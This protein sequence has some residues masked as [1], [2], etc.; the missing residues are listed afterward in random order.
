MGRG[1]LRFGTNDVQW[2]HVAS[3]STTDVLYGTDWGDCFKL[4]VSAVL[5]SAS[6]VQ[7]KAMAFEDASQRLDRVFS[8][9]A[10]WIVAPKHAF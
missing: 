4:H 9:L 6:E 10:G 7:L 1:V 8:L 5:P 3:N 2:S